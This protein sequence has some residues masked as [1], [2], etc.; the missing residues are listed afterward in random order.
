MHPLTSSP[1]RRSLRTALIAAPV[2]AVLL[3]TGGPAAAN[4]P[5]TQVSNDPFT[6]AQAQHQTEVEP[7]TFA[8]GATIV[9]AF[10]V[11]RVAGGG[12]SNI[13]WAT[14]TNGGATWTNGFLPGITTVGGGTYTAASDPVVAFDAQDNVWMIS[15]LGIRSGGADVLTSRSTNGGL[16]WGNPVVT[17]TG[18]L[19]KN[20]IVCDNT[21][22]SPF[23]GNCYTQYDIVSGNQIRMRTSTNGGLTWGAALASGGGATGLG[24]QPVVRPNGTVIVPY[25]ATNA[26]QIRSFRSID[27]GASWRATVL[28]SSISHHTVAGGL[29]ESPLPSAEID[30]AGTVYVAWADCRFRGGCTRNDIIVSE[31][32]SETTWA[33][34]YRVPIDPTASTVEHFAPGIGVDRSTAGGSARI[35]LTYYSYPNSACTAATCQLNVAFI[36]S[37][38]GGT[39]WSAPTQIAGPMTL[40]WLP[41]TT[42]GRMFGDYIS[43]SVLNGGNAW[44]VIPV[45]TVPTGS[46][47]HVPM[48]VPTGGMAV[49]GGALRATGEPATDS[50]TDAGATAV[51]PATAN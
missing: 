38:N 3:L 7:D 28:V 36:S 37:T 16:T 9:S 17:A 22:S 6:D 46:T 48:V 21:A 15:S 25:R 35:G 20:W 27:G 8:F 24:G 43:T 44:T 34:P 2:V 1:H 30:S 26:A 4:V 40:S 12:S 13:G 39:S 31:S 41:N 10:Q 49:T 11:G 47:F 50:A 51:A 32:T 33:A 19:D 42:Q 14:S 29:R 45:A 5:V 18:D 23:F